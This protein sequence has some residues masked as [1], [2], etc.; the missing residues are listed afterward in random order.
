MEAPA[1]VGLDGRGADERNLLPIGARRPD[2][3]DVLGVRAPESMAWPDADAWYDL[4]LE[5]PARE[6]GS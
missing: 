4:D 3:R 6:P 1:V 5:R 2:D